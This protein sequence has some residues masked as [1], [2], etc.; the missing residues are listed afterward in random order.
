MVLDR[1]IQEC[2]EKLPQSFQTEV[3]DYL[4]FLIAKAEKDEKKWMRFSI[5]S[6]ISDIKDEPDLYSQSDLK[7]KY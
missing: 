5:A 4:E 6:V 7:V 3:I 2:L 1:K